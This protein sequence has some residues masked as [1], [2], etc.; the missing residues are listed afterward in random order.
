MNISWK[1]MTGIE[2]IAMVLG[3]SVVA[4][5]VIALVAP[6]NSPINLF[7]PCAAV[8]LFLQAILYWRGSKPLAIG[9]VVI[10]IIFVVV[11]VLE[12]VLLKM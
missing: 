3:I 6:I 8:A 9:L 2:K 1:N 10:S 7:Y 4:F 12:I 11:T 5:Y